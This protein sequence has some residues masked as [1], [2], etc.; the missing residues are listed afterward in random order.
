MQRDAFDRVAFW[1]F[2]RDRSPAGVHATSANASWAYLRALTRLVIAEL[3]DTAPTFLTRSA[4]SGS[5]ST[6]WPGGPLAHLADGGRQLGNVHCNHLKLW[7]FGEVTSLPPA[8]AAVLVLCLPVG[9]NSI[10]APLNFILPF[11][12]AAGSFACLNARLDPGDC[13]ALPRHA[14]NR[15]L[16]LGNWKRQVLTSTLRTHVAHPPKSLF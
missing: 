16:V 15:T 9:H 13:A 3:L 6:P 1:A 8:A 14:P 4:S 11:R 2:Q 5:S 12:S 7:C 10:I